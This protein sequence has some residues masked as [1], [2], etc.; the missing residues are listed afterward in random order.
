MLFL[1]IILSNFAAVKNNCIHLRLKSVFL[2]FHS[3]LNKSL[4]IISMKKTLLLAAA[5]LATASAS[6]S[7]TNQVL[8]GYYFTGM[9]HNGHYAVSTLDGG[10]LTFMDLISGESTTYEGDGYSTEYT[11]GIGNCIS[12]NGILVGSTVP[13][14]NAAYLENGEWHYLPVLNEEYT[15]L[16]NGITADGTVICGNIGTDKIDINSENIMCVPC[17]WY[18]QNDG[19]YSEPVFLPH[20]DKDY[21]GRVPQYVK[22]ISISDD[23]NVVAGQITDYGGFVQQPIVYSRNEKGEWNYE[24][25]C[26]ELINGAKIEF[27]EYPGESPTPPSMDDFMTEEEMA[28]YE[29]AYQEWS[30]T[31]PID[32]SKYPNQEDYMSDESK[33]KYNESMAVYNEKYAEWEELYYPFAD[34]YFESQESTK[35]FVF[36]SCYISPN[37]KYYLTSTQSQGGIWMSNKRKAANALDEGDFDTPEEETTYASPY[38]LNIETGEYST[39]IGNSDIQASFIADDGTVLATSDIYSK[40]QAMVLTPGATEYVPLEVYLAETSPVAVSWMN[41]NMR[42]DMVEYDYDTFEEITIPDVMISGAPYAA[43]D[44]S[45]FCTATLN[46]WDVYDENYYYSYIICADKTVDAVEGVSGNE[47]AVNALK[48]GVV[49]VKGDN[50]TVEV[51]TLGGEKAFEAQGCGMINTG[52]AEGFYIVKATSENGKSVVLKAA[53]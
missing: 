21:T 14:G 48:G 25:L 20:P 29:K 9:S 42:H 40:P 30:T 26:P 32:Y 11:S 2:P 31:Y 15:N 49:S 19:S 52:L 1:L 16:S 3:C 4:I 34:K 37:G 12:N 41:E 28:A 46:V 36:N 43:S 17:V 38:V 45:V 33:A 27:P 7:L 10:I 13:A 24:L 22:A 51:Y 6:A 8:P 47:F 5:A 23:G 18:R 53:F 44:L 39:V 50:A 35:L